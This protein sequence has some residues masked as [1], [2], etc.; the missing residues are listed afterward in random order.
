MI[1]VWKSTEKM[2][3]QGKKKKENKNVEWMKRGKEK[4]WKEGKDVRGSGCDYNRTPEQVISE[5]K[6]K[7][8][9]MDK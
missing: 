8:K 7:E 5:L 2:N 6:K 9:H 4:S 3:G 1:N